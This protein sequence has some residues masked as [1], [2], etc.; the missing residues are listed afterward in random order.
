MATTYEVL[1]LG[2]IA[3]LDPTEGNTVSENASSIVGLTFGSAETPLGYHA[4]R[5]MSPINTSSV[6][7]NAYDKDKTVAND[8]FSIDGGPAQPLT[9]S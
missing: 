3:A 5:V 2:N 7:P 8:T 4:Q 6:D 9:R 1:F